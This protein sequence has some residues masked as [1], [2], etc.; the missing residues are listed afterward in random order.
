VKCRTMGRAEPEMRETIY[1]SAL[2]FDTAGP[3]AVQFW[4]WP[5]SAGSVQ[6]DEGW[7]EPHLT[8]QCAW[9]GK[10]GIGIVRAHTLLRV[11][12]HDIVRGGSIQVLVHC[13]GYSRGGVSLDI[14]YI[15]L[16]TRYSPYGQS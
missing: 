11:S 10:P 12:E 13:R 7:G 15:L 5:A 16:A 3:F 8:W 6:Q 2:R 1:R 4:A 9:A 14:A